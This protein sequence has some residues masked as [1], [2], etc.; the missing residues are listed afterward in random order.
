VDIVPTLLALLGVS[1]DESKFQGESVLQGNPDRKYIFTMDACA[2]FI[3]AINQ[4][5][6]KVSAGLDPDDVTA[7]NLAK[8]PGETFPLNE[9]SFKPQIDAIIKFRNYQ[10]RMFETYN[11]AL[12]EGF[13]F[14]PKHLF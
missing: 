7:F 12:I 1:C 2:K 6:N 9:N 5:M 8:N 14:P 4:Q 11:Q 10:S 3:S 13:Q